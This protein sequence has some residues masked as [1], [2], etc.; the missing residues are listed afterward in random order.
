MS[1]DSQSIADRKFVVRIVYGIEKGID[2]GTYDAGQRSDI[3]DRVCEYIA[4]ARWEG[5]RNG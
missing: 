3:I 1:Q 2:R 4:K 5:E